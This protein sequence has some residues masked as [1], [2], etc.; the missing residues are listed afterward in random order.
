M[1]DYS[2]SKIYLLKSKNSDKVYVG[3]TTKTLVERFTGHK[4]D[5]K[6]SKNYITSFEILKYPDCFIELYMN[7]P[8]ST[9]KELRRKEGEIIK[10]LNCVNKRVDGRTYKEYFLDNEQKIKK[11]KKQYNEIHKE[12]NRIY[13]KQYYQQNKEI[14]SKKQK[15]YNQ[16][17]KEKLQLCKKKYYQQN[18]EKLQ[19]NQKEKI[20]CEICGSIFSRSNKARHYKTKKHM[21]VY[22]RI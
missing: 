4:K 19:K 18:K 22:T 1:V 20:K 9:K 2:K 11:Y 8:C 7:Y 21:K 16:K 12:E 5:F 3:S 14:L 17:N 13:M 10:L 15:I 6:Y